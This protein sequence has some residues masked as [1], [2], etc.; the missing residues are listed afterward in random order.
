M[1]TK[2]YK[3]FSEADL[4]TSSVLFMLISYGRQMSN[5]QWFQMEQLHKGASKISPKLC[6][7]LNNG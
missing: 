5:M 1:F 7:P 4:Q 3:Q 2:C 6:Q